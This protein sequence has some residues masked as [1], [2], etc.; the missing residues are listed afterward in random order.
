MPK[1]SVIPLIESIPGLEWV[2]LTQDHQLKP[3]DCSN[4][5]LN[6]FLFNDSKDYQDFHLAVTYILE[7]KDRTI[8]YYSLQNDNLQI[9]SNSSRDFK[10]VL[11]KKGKSKRDFM[12]HMFNFT[13]FPAVKIARFAVDKEFQ[14]QGLGRFL[15]DSLTYEFATDNKTG[16]T[17]ITVDSINTK[18]AIK[19]YT[20]N[21]FSM[22]QP[23][24]DSVLMYKCLL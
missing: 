7:T 21:G 2:R 3:F 11:R 18:R 10:S 4:K 16:C 20:N 12:Y 15:L 24:K 1:E 5:D 13:Q 23:K 9:S 22:L 17:F 6:D 8:A 14:S 19:F